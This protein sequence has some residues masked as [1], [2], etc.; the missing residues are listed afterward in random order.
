MGYP[1]P[2]NQWNRGKQPEFAMRKAFKI[3]S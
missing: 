1:R 2:V 3:A